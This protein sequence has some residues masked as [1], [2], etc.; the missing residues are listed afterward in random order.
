MGTFKTFEDLAAHLEEGKS[1]L[2]FEEK[3]KAEVVMTEDIDE[4]VKNDKHNFHK[5]VRALGSKDELKKLGVLVMNYGMGYWCLSAPD[6]IWEKTYKE[7]VFGYSTLAWWGKKTIG[8]D[9]EDEEIKAKIPTW[10]EK[11]KKKRFP[12]IVGH[13]INGEL[14]WVYDKNPVSTNWAGYCKLENSKQENRWGDNVYLG[15]DIYNDK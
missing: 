2:T 8:R 12:F 15:G 11:K 3:I 6:E 1:A 7:K 10:N 4:F 5:I 14:G 9:E 13:K